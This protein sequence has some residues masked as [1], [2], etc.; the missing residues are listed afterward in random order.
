MAT[1][2]TEDTF[3]IYKNGKEIQRFHEENLSIGGMEEFI[4][5]II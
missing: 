4:T 5:D 2:I 1:E 3:L